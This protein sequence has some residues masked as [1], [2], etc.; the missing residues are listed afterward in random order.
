M[1]PSMQ[2]L[3]IIYIHIVFSCHVTLLLFFLD[4]S[5]G[6]KR[7]TEIQSVEKLPDIRADEGAGPSRNIKLQNESYAG[8]NTKL[9]ASKDRDGKECEHNYII[10][11][12]HALLS[13]G[14]TLLCTCNC[15]FISCRCPKWK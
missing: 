9:H 2:F 5:F 10:F 6:S 4:Q 8:L 7:E 12:Y 13:A 15:D 14:T 1:W 11:C 3:Y